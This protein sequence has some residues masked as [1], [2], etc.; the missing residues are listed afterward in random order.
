MNKRNFMHLYRKWLTRGY[1]DM[2]VKTSDFTKEQLRAFKHLERVSRP[3]GLT[4]LH[5]R[6]NYRAQ[7]TCVK[8]SMALN[9]Y[10]VRLP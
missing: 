3:R 5:Y 1:S 6:I 9:R 7:M 4:D 10:L 8:S 2:R